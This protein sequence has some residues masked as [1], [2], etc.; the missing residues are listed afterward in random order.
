VRA[1]PGIVAVPAGNSLRAC[2]SEQIGYE[3]RGDRVNV[4]GNF[5]GDFRASD[6]DQLRR[7]GGA[8]L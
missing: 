2:R 8:R 1:R 5:W 3:E 7:E 6:A 4:L